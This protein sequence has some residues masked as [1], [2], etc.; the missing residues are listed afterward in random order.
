MRTVRNTSGS[1]AD[2][3]RF[4]IASRS[5][6]IEQIHRLNYKTFVC[7]I[8]QHERRA[9]K[10]LV[11]R[12]HDENTY[13]VA[14]HDDV[15]IGMVAVRSVRPFSLDQKLS[16]LDAYLPEHNSKCEMRLLVVEKAFRSTG[17]FLGLME[18]V[19]NHIL[20]GGFDLAVISGTTRQL[21]L[22]RS[23]GFVAFGDLVGT[24]DA[25]YQPMYITPV[26]FA[27]ARARFHVSLRLA[28]AATTPNTPM[29]ED[30]PSRKN[31]L[32]GPV[33]VHA[34]VSKALS[35]RLVSHRS[36]GFV[37][38]LQRVK[39]TLCELTCARRVELMMGAGTLANDAIAAQLGRLDGRGIVLSNGEFGERLIDHATRS[40]L[41][42]D[43]HQRSWN[44]EFDFEALESALR[45]NG[46]ISW[47]W[48]VHCE[49]ST[50][51][52]NNVNK[53][54]RLC[55]RYDVKLC[56]D[57]I[58]SIGAVPVDLSGV[59]FAS[60]VSGKALGSCAGVAMVYYNHKISNERS[61]PRYLDIGYY[62]SNNGVP[63]TINT[64]LIAA[65]DAALIQRD[66]RAIEK[67]GELS[68]SLAAR[69]KAAG[70]PVLDSED[71]CSAVFTIP[72]PDDVSSRAIGDALCAR[73]YLLSYESAYLLQ[74]NWI[75]ICLMGQC[76]TVSC[77]ALVDNLADLIGAQ[78]E[79][80]SFRASPQRGAA[81]V[82]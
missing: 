13:V 49:T 68:N 32:P 19:H 29:A 30:R 31:F 67:V 71:R 38:R 6:H 63:F 78:Q 34:S 64:N 36:E 43:R 81:A 28:K 50:G 37:A 76:N 18:V 15:V 56:L 60:G 70:I 12:F 75:Q 53:L 44:T 23:L 54:Q 8:P 74:R 14:L 7:E 4:E 65:L 27:A 45:L 20:D 41:Q 10:R 48:A 61:M 9:D 46:E 3:V 39:Q 51:M 2:N 47:I 58:S 55:Q 17:V 72:L 57:C 11:D 16:D 1:G 62:A 22:Y 42:F 77:N 82:G 59:Y 66:P 73:G 5:E 26:G 79:M 24:T 40:G 21:S 80:S 25:M 35:D 69:L 33:A 52:L